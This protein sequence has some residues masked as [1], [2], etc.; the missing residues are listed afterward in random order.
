[1]LALP[2]NPTL[3]LTVN[4]RLARWLKLQYNR[5]KAQTQTVWETPSILQFD[6]WLRQ[7]W[8]ESW[9]RRYVLTELQA[10]HLW[11]R[12]I[13]NDPETSRLD[14]LHLRGAAKQAAEAHRLLHQYGVTDEPSH[15]SLSEETLSFHRWRGE[16]QQQL[17]RWNAIDP[18]ELL[19]AVQKGMEGGT[20]P[21]PPSVIFAGF[22]EWTPELERFIRFL[23]SKSVSVSHYPSAPEPQPETLR[24]RLHENKRTVQ[25]YPDPREEVIQCARW[26]RSVMQPQKTIGIVATRMEDYRDL[27]VREFKAELAPQSVYCWQGQEA[28]FNIS[29]G[30]PLA[31]ERAVDLA[32]KLLETLR[33]S[34]PVGLYSQVLLSPCFGSW[35]SER[36]ARWDRGYQVRKYGLL[37]VDVTR[38]LN[39]LDRDALPAF[40]KAL[41]ALRDWTQTTGNRP[42]SEWARQI[43]KFL[44]DMG[45]PH[46]E[47]AL[48]SREFQVHDSWN[49]S[50][51]ALATL[52]GVLGSIHRT[53]AAATLKRIAQEKVFQPKTREEPIQVVGL[54]EAAGM[55]FDHTWILGCHAETLPALHDPNPFIPIHL[56]RK[57]QLPH[58]TPTRSLRFYENVLSNLLSTAPDVQLSY[59]E[60][61]GDQELLLSPMLKNVEVVRV[62]LTTLPSHRVIDLFQEQTILEAVEDRLTLPMTTQERA[63]LRGGHSILK[64]QAECPFR[65]FALHRLRAETPEWREFELSALERGN[66]VHTI[67]EKFWFQIKTKRNLEAR[68][69]D[70]TVASEVEK[71]VDAVLQERA[72]LFYGQEEFKKL[73]R[74]RLCGLILEWLE[75]ERKREDFEVMDAEKKIELT[76]GGLNLSLQ[77]DRIDQLGGDRKALIDYKTG[78]GPLINGWYDERILEPQ[79]PLYCLAHPADAILFAKVNKGNCGFSGMGRDGLNLPGFNNR[80]EDKG[81]FAD[82]DTAVQAWRSRLEATAGLFLQG[83]LKVDPAPKAN[84]CRNCELPTLCRKAELLESA[85]EDRDEDEEA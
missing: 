80:R 73:E 81:G 32:L 74:E 21:V 24:T 57:H 68:F 83:D 76:L 75:V 1:M 3:V 40:R 66:L 9:P 18:C 33:P 77:I 35:D 65:A 70:G 46:G 11:E 72:S 49:E 55:Q 14:L 60:T 45:W 10:L 4:A 54:L 56:Q 17:K 78:G 41:E 16:Y 44:H 30:Q 58:C 64:H 29:L 31:R 34:L 42:P 8:V 20:I 12:I 2:D 13:R 28:P 50:L 48:T 69:A 7:T 79:L 23:E 62:D 38:E 26:V 67:L 59:P 63:S 61:A 82:W 22:D 71:L 47:R 43:A 15:Y 36:Q 6:A 37:W 84:P 39:A 19:T 51:D 85:T 5:Q 52:D 53:T 27:L 25:E